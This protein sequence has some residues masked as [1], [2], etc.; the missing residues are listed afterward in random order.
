MYTK[1][2]DKKKLLTGRA[3]ALGMDLCG[4]ADAAMVDEQAP[5]GFR[6]ADLLEGARSVVIIAQRMPAGSLRTSGAG[7]AGGVLFLRSFWNSGLL[8]DAAAQ[9]LARFIEERTGAPAVPIPA[10]TPLRIY[11]G[12]P[13][14]VVSLKHIAQLAGLGSLGK[15][16]L[17]IN[18]AHGNT[19]RLAGVITRAAFTPDRPN[20]SDPCPPGCTLCIDAC[21]VGAIRDRSIAINDCMRLSIRH[22]MMQP[23]ALTRFLLWLSKKWKGAHRMVEDMNNMLVTF[24]AESCTRCLEACPHYRRVAARYAG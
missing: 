8:L 7:D 22:P 20:L 12:E 3:A 10:Y 14:G 16:S 6:P 19:L 17:L 24:Y 4:I 13:R 15:N 9:T 18:E 23:Y 21:P 11:G 1:R 2:S 5:D